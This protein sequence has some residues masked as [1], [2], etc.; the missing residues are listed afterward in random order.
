MIIQHFPKDSGPIILTG[1]P[2]TYTYTLLSYFIE[3][4]AEHGIL[5]LLICY[6]LIDILTL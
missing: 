5:I 3:K 1:Q 2:Y 6:M 4:T